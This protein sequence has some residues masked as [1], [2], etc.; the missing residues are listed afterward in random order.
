MSD[1]QNLTYG[2]PKVGGAIHVAPLGS[3]L[4]TDATTA[5]DAAF[6][7]LGYISEDGLTNANS[8]ESE[9]I[10][11]WADALSRLMDALPDV[12]L[13]EEAVHVW[14]M[15][16][17]GERMATPREIKNA[18]YVVR[19]R[20]EGDPAKSRVLA[21]A[22]AQ[23]QELRDR[24]IAAGTFGDAIGYRPPLSLEKKRAGEIPADAQRRW[25]EVLGKFGV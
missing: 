19:D 1:V 11:A 4:P 22:R 5:L 20:W 7:S 12:N 16:L 24:Q 13:W 14:S 6:K 21:Q 18:V 15:E 3:T 25:R 9:T 2:K 17:V 23:G 10:K 8:P